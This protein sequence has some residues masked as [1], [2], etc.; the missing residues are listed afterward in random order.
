L[1]HKLKPEPGNQTI[2][3][4]TCRSICPRINEQVKNRA[5]DHT[6]ADLVADVATLVGMALKMALAASGA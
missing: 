6:M 5:H 3:H 4:A 2:K 1:Y